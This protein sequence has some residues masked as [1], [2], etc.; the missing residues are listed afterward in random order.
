MKTR[1]IWSSTQM[2]FLGAKNFYALEGST[3]VV[4]SE[5]F[6]LSFL[7]AFSSYFFGRYPCLQ[8][9]TPPPWCILFAFSAGTLS[10]SWTIPITL[11]ILEDGIAK[12][13]PIFVNVSRKLDP[14]D[15]AV[16]YVAW[17]TGDMTTPYVRILPSPPFL[18]LWM[19][20]FFTFTAPFPSWIRLQSMIGELLGIPRISK[21]SMGRWKRD[22]FGQRFRTTSWGAKNLYPL[23]GSRIGDR[24][25][26]FPFFPW[27][28]LII[29]FSACS[30]AYSTSQIPSWM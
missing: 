12:L 2:N 25:F 7:P 28:S 5:F 13:A 24:S 10:R 15:L 22:G 29:L 18:S 9:C 8:K 14:R 1:R 20:D 19:R 17:S 23:K 27:N 16:V 4:I 3:A 11:I 30:T 26:S 6:F 21:L